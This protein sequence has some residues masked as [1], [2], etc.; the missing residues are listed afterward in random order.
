MV[1][2]LE[3]LFVV[4]EDTTYRDQYSFQTDIC[5]QIAYKMCSDELCTSEYTS[6]NNV[7]LVDVNLDGKVNQLSISTVNGFLNEIFFI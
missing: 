7:S 5:N 1:I 6:Q 4:E 2:D 3:S